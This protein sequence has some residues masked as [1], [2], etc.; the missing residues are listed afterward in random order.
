MGENTV[1][2]EKIIHEPFKIT[3]KEITLLT[4]AEYKKNETRISAPPRNYNGNIPSWWLKTP[5]K[6]KC[7]QVRCVEYDSYDNWQ[8]TI[9]SVDADYEYERGIRPVLVVEEH[10]KA[11]E[12]IRL[13]GYEWMVLH[14]GKLLCDGLIQESHRFRDRIWN[15]DEETIYKDGQWVKNEDYEEDYV[16]D[17]NKYS[18]SDLKWALE[19]WLATQMER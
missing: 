16:A 6:N 1:T 10:C 19:Q 2:A 4:E 14:N 8:P 13:F 11:G 3:I 17:A 15:W 12:K 5:D 7:Q 18:K 9:D